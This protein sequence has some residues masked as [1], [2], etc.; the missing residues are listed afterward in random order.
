MTC[1]NHHNRILDICYGS[2]PGAYR[3]KNKIEQKFEQ[4]NYRAALQGIKNMANVNTQSERRRVS[5]EGV[6]ESSMPNELNKFYTGFKRSDLSP[7]AV[8]LK[9]IFTPCATFTPQ[10]IDVRKLLKST[11][12]PWD[13][14]VRRW[15]L[16]TSINVLVPSLI[17]P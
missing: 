15:T 1:A 10:P 13:Q 11:P 14:M 16:W 9:Q 12:K 5:V 3:Y 7:D 4:G 8:Q 2:A 6:S 17:T